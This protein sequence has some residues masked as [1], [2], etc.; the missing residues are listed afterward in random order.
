MVAIS[1]G[2]SCLCITSVTSDQLPVFRG[3]ALKKDEG[4][5]PGGYPCPAALK[6]ADLKNSSRCVLPDLDKIVWRKPR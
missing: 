3:G 2:N 1:R 4:R 5:R 6:A